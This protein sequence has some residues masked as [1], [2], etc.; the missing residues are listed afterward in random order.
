MVCTYGKSGGI[1]GEVIRACAHTHTC[2]GYVGP[3]PLGVSEW[4]RF[5]HNPGVRD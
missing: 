1:V 3:V 4:V 5:I 2:G